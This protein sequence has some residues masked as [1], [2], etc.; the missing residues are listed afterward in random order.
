MYREKRTKKQ[1]KDEM[2]GIL[3]YIYILRE[4]KGVG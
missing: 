3:I 2:R 1:R 4:R